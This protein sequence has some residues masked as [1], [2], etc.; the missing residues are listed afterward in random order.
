MGGGVMKGS[1]RFRDWIGCMIITIGIVGF[2]FWRISQLDRME[3]M[4]F[5][6][7]KI[8]GQTVNGD[9]IVK[10]SNGELALKKR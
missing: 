7:A 2:A 1:L 9:S 4:R 8:V 3:A 5:R 10:L 6:G